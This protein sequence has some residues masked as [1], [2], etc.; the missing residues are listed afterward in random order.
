MVGISVSIN[1]KLRKQ[2]SL[3]EWMI[4]KVIFIKFQKMFT[5]L[6]SRN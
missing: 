3:N 4:R 2:T 1:F 5:K 6:N